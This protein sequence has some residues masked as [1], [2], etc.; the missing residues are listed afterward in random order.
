MPCNMEIE[1]NGQPFPHK[2]GKIVCVGRNYAEH[3]KELNNPVPENPLLFIKPASC[4]QSLPGEIEI[5]HDR[6]PVHYECELALLIGEPGL[7]ATTRDWRA[8]VAGVGLALDLTL[9]DLQQQLKDKGHPWEISKCF[10]GACPVSG[11][12]SPSG[13][14]Q[15]CRFDFSMNGELRQRG[16]AGQMITPIEPLLSYITRHFSLQ[17]GDLVLT[18]TP[19]GVGILHPGD[20]FELELVEQ[21]SCAGSVAAQH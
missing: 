20:Q 6:G 18:G 17:P 19:A 13:D 2:P 1:L 9:R 5:P 21:F 14:L 8:S 16:D 3:A 7:D 15:Q 11:F 12:V 4:L 10:D